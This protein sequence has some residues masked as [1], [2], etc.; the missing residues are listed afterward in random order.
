[1]CLKTWKWFLFSV[2]WFAITVHSAIYHSMTN[3]VI[4]KFM[5]FIWIC[6]N[7]EKR[8]IFRTKNSSNAFIDSRILWIFRSNFLFFT[9]FFNFWF[10]F[11]RFVIA[12]PCFDCTEQIQFSI[13]FR[14]CYVNFLFRILLKSNILSIA[15]C[16]PSSIRLWIVHLFEQILS[17]MPDSEEVFVFAQQ[18]CSCIWWYVCVHM[19]VS[20]PRRCVFCAVT[21][22]FVSVSLSF[23][24]HIVTW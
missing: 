3:Y 6:R 20:Q 23:V 14:S 15:F 12:F 9:F 19:V 11:S 18:F 22:W 10:F 8:L 17:I 7:N 21:S 4:W 5:K 16:F 13:M 1:M 24:S 2:L